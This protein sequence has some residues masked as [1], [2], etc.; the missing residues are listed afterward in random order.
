MKIYL[1]RHGEDIPNYRGGW[2]NGSLTDKGIVQAKS[3]AKYL[4]EELKGKSIKLISSDIK[5]ASQTAE[6]ISER[7]GISIVYEEEIRE[8]NNGELAS[9]RNEEA[10]IKYKGLYLVP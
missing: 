5:R 1:V 7:L 9:I 2:S 4:S 8:I 6:Y 10:E 3:V